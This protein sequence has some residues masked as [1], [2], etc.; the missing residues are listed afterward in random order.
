MG[1]LLSGA[2]LLAALCWADGEDRCGADSFGCLPKVMQEQKSK[3]TARLGS[4]WSSFG[5]HGFAASSSFKGGIE[6]Y[7]IEITGLEDADDIGMGIVG[8][9]GNTLDYSLYW[10][11]WRYNCHCFG[12]LVVMKADF[13][14][15]KS[16]TVCK[17][18][19]IDPKIIFSLKFKKVSVWQVWND[20]SPQ[21][22]QSVSPGNFDIKT[23]KITV[24]VDN[25]KKILWDRYDQTILVFN[26]G[27][28]V[29]FGSPNN[30][31]HREKSGTRSG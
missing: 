16:P 7:D 2:V 23:K 26:S 8:K 14:L 18:F 21:K 29:I 11:S 27:R 15:C 19:S 4:N 5:I 31:W 28:Y 6:S 12:M 22:L 24:N 17:T 13:S 30:D 9:Q 3:L 1:R 25:A 20:G 10:Q